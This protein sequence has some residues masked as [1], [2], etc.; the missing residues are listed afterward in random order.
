MHG[1]NCSF[2]KPAKEKVKSIAQDLQCMQDKSNC[3]LEFSEEFS[4]PVV[5]QHFPMFRKSDNECHGSDPDLLTDPNDKSK[6]FKP[7]WDCLSKESSDFLL[8]QIRPRLILSG[9]THHGCKILHSLKGEI[10][11]ISSKIST[12]RK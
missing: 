8:E 6:L 12:T 1:D 4:H 9:H 11:R 2:C 10:Y 3:E 7:Q 5:L